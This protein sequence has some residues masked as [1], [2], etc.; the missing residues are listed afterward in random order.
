MRIANIIF[1]LQLTGLSILDGTAAAKDGPQSASFKLSAPYRQTEFPLLS[2][3]EYFR[4]KWDGE[5]LVSSGLNASPSN[6]VVLVNDRSGDIV[7]K[8]TLWFDDAEEVN[9]ADA[10]VASDGSVVL[11]AGARRQ[12]GTISNFLAKVGRDGSVKSVV[13]I[14]PYVAYYVRPAS[15]GTVWTLGRERDSQLHGKESPVLR[16]YSFEK[17]QLATA[18]DS[19]T[20]RAKNAAASDIAWYAGFPG[21]LTVGNHG[22]TLGFYSARSSEWITVDL[23]S[24][25]IVRQEITPLPAKIEVTGVAYTDSGEVFASVFAPGETASVS[26]LAKLKSSPD[27]AS[28]VMVSGSAASSSQEAGD[29]PLYQLL[30]CSGSALVYRTENYP[31]NIVAWS[32]A[33]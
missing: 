28:W 18:L 6:P 7:L 10:A 11:A 22:K 29:H 24:H 3:N 16:Q 33:P 23:N 4:H 2:S 32:P 9:V 17:G 25:A 21:G 26:G 19:A 30:G 1:V 27:K 20:F 14:S 15:D 12:D 5:Y 31:S 8:A 13:Q